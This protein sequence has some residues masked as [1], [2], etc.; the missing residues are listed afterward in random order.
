MFRSAAPKFYGDERVRDEIHRGVTSHPLADCVPQ[1][2]CTA[3]DE[4]Q[5]SAYKKKL[6]Q[7]AKERKKLKKN[8]GDP[9]KIVD[10]KH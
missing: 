1:P 2:G 5:W 4:H 8:G 10:E 9:L 3:M 7:I 6:A